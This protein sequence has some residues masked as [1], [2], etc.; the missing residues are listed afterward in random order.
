M[1]KLPKTNPNEAASE[2]EPVFSVIEELRAKLMIA[3]R[4]VKVNFNNENKSLHG[5]IFVLS[6]FKKFKMA[7]R[8]FVLISRKKRL[9]AKI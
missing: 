8:R 2:A 5:S 7:Q 6:L 9:C 4:A 1:H 3:T